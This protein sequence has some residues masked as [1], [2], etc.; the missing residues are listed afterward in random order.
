[1]TAPGRWLLDRS[2]RRTLARWD[3]RGGP[4]RFE[5]LWMSRPVVAFIAGVVFLLV[6]AWPRPF[7]VGLA[8]VVAAGAA[9]Y[10]LALSHSARW[11]G[12]LHREWQLSD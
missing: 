11:L 3:R 12:R 2:T 4:G 9:L 5:Q 8:V 6:T 1:M 7:S 10:G